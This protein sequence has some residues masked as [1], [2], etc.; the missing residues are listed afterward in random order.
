M[1]GY[2]ARRFQTFLFAISFALICGTAFA[3]GS[4]GTVIHE[5]RFSGGDLKLQI[6]GEGFISPSLPETHSLQQPGLSTLPVRQMTFVLPVGVV[7][8]NLIIE[9]LETHTVKLDAPLAQEGP[10]VSASGQ[11]IETSVMKRG[12]THFPAT[13]GEFTGSHVWRGYQLVTANVYPVREINSNDA[14]QVEFLDA[15]AVKAVYGSGPSFNDI[16]VRERLVHGEDQAN[17]DILRT[18]VSNPEVLGSIFRQSGSVELEEKGGF[19]PTRTP[20]LSGSA[21]SYLIITNE[22]MASEFQRLADFKTSMG[23]P[24]VVTTR[25]YIAANFRNGSDIQETIRLFIREAYQKWGTEYVLLAGDSDILPARYVVNTF[26]P[27]GSSTS[28]PVDLYFACLDGDWNANSNSGYGEPGLAADGGDEADFAEEVYLGRAPVS[29]T[30]AAAVFVNKVM[31]YERTPAGSPWTNNAL[32]AAEMLFPGD[33]S[34]GDYIILDGAQFANQLVTELLEP[35]TDMNYMRM[36]ET[37]I[38][39]PMDGQLSVSAIR[40]SMN[41]GHY[42]IVNQIGHGYYFNM[43][44]GDG[45][46]LCKDADALENGDHLFMLYA[47]N[48]ASAAFDYSCLMERFLQNPNGGSVVSIGAVR[49]AFPTNANNYQQEFFDNLF[50]GSAKRVGRLVA[51]SR[52]PFVGLTNNNY[53]DR[54]T[55]ENYTLLGDPTIPIWSGVPGSLDITNA[56]EINLGDQTYPVTVTSEGSP[57]ADALVCLQMEGDDIAAASTDA[58]GQVTLDFLAT[59][60]GEAQLTVSGTNIEISTQAVT[61]SAQGAYVALGD[62]LFSDDAIGASSGN[63][64]LSIEAG[65]TVEFSPQLTE[66]GGAAATTVSASLSTTAVGVSITTATADYSDLSA[67]G[68]AS[69]VSPFIVSFDSSLVDGTAVTFEM[70]VSY[71]GSETSTSEW[72]MVLQAPEVEVIAIDWDDSTWGNGDG[73]LDGSERVGLTV[74]LKNFGAGTLDHFDAVLRTDDSNITIYD[75]LGTYND[76]ELMAETEGVVNFSMSLALAFQ[77]SHSRVVLVDNYGRTLVQDLV[78]ERPVAPVGFETDSSEGSDI[79]SLRWNPSESEN[80]LGY[81]VYRSLSQLGPFSQVNADILT[82]SSYFRDEGLELMTMYYYKVV[83]LTEYFIPSESSLIISQSTAPPEIEGFPMEFANETSGHCAVGDIDGD[84]TLEIVLASNE[85]HIWN[86]DGTEFMDGDNDSQTLGPF[87]NLDTVLDPAG[88]TLAHLDDEPGMEIIVSERGNGY[89]IHIFK[90]DGTELD[91]WPQTMNQW[92]WATPAVADIDGDGD[93]EIVVNTLNGTVWAWH[94]DGTEVRDGDSNGST[95]GVFF[96]RAGATWEWS[97]SGPAL[98]DLDDDGAC[99]IIFGTRNDD[100]GLRQ[101]MAIKYDGTSVEGFPY[102]GT[103]PFVFNPVVGDLNGDGTFEI[104][105]SDGHGK[106]YVIQQDGTDYPG[107]PIDPGVGGMV[108]AGP[109]CALANMDA[110]D[111]LEII[112]T[113][114]VTGHR[115]DMLVVDTDFVGGTS[116]DILSGFPIELPGSSE[117]SPVVGDIDGDGVCEILLGIGGGDTEAPNNLY[118]FHASGSSVDG[119]PIALNGPLRSS[120]VICDLD[121]DSDVDIVYGSWDRLIHVWDMPFAYNRLNVPWPTFQGNMQRT[122]VFF[123]L[124]LVPVQGESVPDV[125]LLVGSPYPNPFNPSTSVKL[126][127]ASDGSGSADLALAVYNIQGRR[128]RQLH[129]GRIASGWHT[130]VWDGQDDSGRGVSSGMYFMRAVSGD[131]STVHKMTLVK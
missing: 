99:D 70:A 53:V 21:V 87:T 14:P 84:G 95:N 115:S 46:F 51:L 41:S 26:Y 80:I 2:R 31:T 4:G 98:F 93:P 96:V 82:S 43:S 49:A 60:S 36:Y 129:T 64:N 76:I 125:N 108:N 18:F 73:D 44:V 88:V 128:V 86:S 117:A 126:Y 92:N 120:A 127:V 67:S 71:N 131:M 58:S 112:W 101:V 47:L 42:G 13:W 3:A 22:E 91:G 89:K 74:R 39:Y 122:G 62:V 83:T 121:F 48:C 63:G 78:L 33:Y 94:A 81:N 32:F 79:I 1:R 102:I 57:V 6:N 45:D 12:E 16:A 19:N 123:S 114:N 111:D 118:A 65:E 106:L 25:E 66:T 75:S 29:T 38:G 97:L 68:V 56:S 30:E 61:I 7:V 72:T 105:I 69:P 20:S 23:I 124:D 52:L 116:G 35:C 103:G 54:W 50:C 5:G 28:I 17:E 10:L 100:S 40:D 107:F 109:S 110:D 24:T 90:K 34:A 55:F 113:A 59:L 130:L 11:I 85:I 15:F 9:P 104:V 27:A 119:F 8:E 37:D 77:A